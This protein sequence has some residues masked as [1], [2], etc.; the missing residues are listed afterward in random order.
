VG[1]K[2]DWSAMLTIHSALRRD[3]EKVAR[4]AG[5]K[6]Q[7]DGDQ[8][9]ATLGW[10]QFKRF[11]IIHHQVEDDVL[12][13]VL[14]TNVAAFSDQVAVVD[15]LEAEHAPIEPLLEAADEAAGGRGGESRRFGDIVDELVV[16]LTWHL[17]HEES[18]GRDLIDSSLSDEEWQAFARSHGQ[19]LIGDAPTYVP[20][21][22][23][24]AD[25]ESAERFLANIPPSLATSYREQWAPSYAAVNHWETD[26]SGLISPRND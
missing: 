5:R 25:P 26:R 4:L 14:R 20:W 17:A 22:L 21:L 12:W 9:R 10:E 13:P 2:L 19:R 7:R 18:E 16:K 8:L 6:E 1:S 15:A 11:L 3:L 23:D 24:G